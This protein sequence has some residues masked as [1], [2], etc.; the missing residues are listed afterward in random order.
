MFGS[1]R[2]KELRK[3]MTSARGLGDQ[4]WPLE[5]QEI[6]SISE[7]LSRILEPDEQPL[8]WA[9]QNGLDQRAWLT[10][11]AVI[12]WTASGEFLRIAFAKIRHLETNDWAA[13][14]VTTDQGTA[15]IPFHW[16]ANPISTTEPS[17]FALFHTDKP[18]AFINYIRQQATQGE[19]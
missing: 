12:G 13:L 8:F 19:G 6:S 3:Q 15:S 11:R 2:E 10:D 4:Q 5:R 16:D 9:T 18:A 7:L 17:Y 1:S 14:V